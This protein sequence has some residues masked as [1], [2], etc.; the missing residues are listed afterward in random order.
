MV[1]VFCKSQG[2]PA[3][4]ACL[5]EIE[6]AKARLDLRA[7]LVSEEPGEGWTGP[8]GR[9]D[10][11]RLAEMLSG[12]DPA[13]SVALICGP[14]PMVTATSDALIDLGMPM[15]N[16]VYERFDYS[17]A[18]SSRQ[19]RTR[20]QRFLGLGAALALGVALFAALRP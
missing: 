5:P 17:G 16:V 10:T 6:A 20:M 19:D 15:R 9:L 13:R 7:T 2:R 11:N 1:R 3:N 12:L 14:G 8:L 18:G 4:F